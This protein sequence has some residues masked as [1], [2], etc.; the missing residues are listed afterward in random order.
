MSSFFREET[1]SQAD[2]FKMLDDKV[3]QGAQKAAFAAHRR[4]RIHSVSTIM[5]RFSVSTNRSRHSASV[6]RIS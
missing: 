6:S 2:F 1:G 4:N 3:E 5:I